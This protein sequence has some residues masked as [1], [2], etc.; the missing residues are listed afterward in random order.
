MILE[1]QILFVNAPGS[2]LVMG[3]R[4]FVIRD[5]DVRVI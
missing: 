2:P 1:F 4:M 5:L 3:G